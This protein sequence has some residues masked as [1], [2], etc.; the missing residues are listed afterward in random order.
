MKH[1]S[2]RTVEL[3]E[4]AKEWAGPKVDQA[5]EWAGPRVED[6]MDWAGPKIDQ[7][8]DWAVPRAK[9]AWRKGVK[10]AAP[11]IEHAAEVVSPKIDD[12]RDKIVDE[13]IPKVV[14]AV[15]AAAATAQEAQEE[16]RKRTKGAAKVLKGDAKAKPKRSGKKWLVIG[17]VGAAAAGA[18]VAWNRRQQQED[19]WAEEY[20][21]YP[22]VTHRD[23]KS[24]RLNSSHVAV[25]WGVI[26]R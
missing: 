16:A 3:A 23:R 2:N 6:A 15:S 9:K 20:E 13:L 7:A 10:V 14:A 4:Q 25:A 8:K 12:A 26:C 11:R 19:P 24:T 1:P 22:P 21:P 18:Y 5:V 17:L